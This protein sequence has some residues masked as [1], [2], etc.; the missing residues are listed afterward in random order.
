MRQNYPNPFNPA[1]TIKFD[2]PVSDLVS[3]QIF[4]ITGKRVKEL[5][6]NQLFNAGSHEVRFEGSNL[7]SGAYF[8][9][10][11]TPKYTDV[12]KMVLVK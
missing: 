3:I 8:Y 10:I 7:S 6:N 12:K 4:D 11:T 1:T 5:A 2:L 9:R